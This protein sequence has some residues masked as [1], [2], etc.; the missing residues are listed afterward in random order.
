MW[1]LS[2]HRFAST[3]LANYRLCSTVVFIISKNLP[4]SGPTQFKYTSFKG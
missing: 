2:V 4:V 1:F 3:D